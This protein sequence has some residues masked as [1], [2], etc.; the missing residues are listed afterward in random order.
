MSRMNQ[1]KKKQKT[2]LPIPF[3]RRILS[4]FGITFTF[5]CPNNNLGE[6]RNKTKTSMLLL[7]CFCFMSSMC[8]EIDETKNETYSA[9]MFQNQ[10]VPKIKINK[11]SKIILKTVE[12][13]NL[14]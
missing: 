2:I 4:Y 8:F 6:N 9:P 7:F 1:K 3:F 10:K 5:S 14:D 13:C 11:N 12:N